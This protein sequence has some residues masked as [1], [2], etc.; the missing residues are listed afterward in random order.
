MMICF[1]YEVT[2]DPRTAG[3]KVGDFCARVRARSD[4]KVRAG[5]FHILPSISKSNGPILMRF[6]HAYV[7]SRGA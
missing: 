4:L 3:K 2:T 7:P 1:A 6:G 5:D